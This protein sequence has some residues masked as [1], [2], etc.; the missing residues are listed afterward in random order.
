MS[1]LKDLSNEKVAVVTGSASGIGYHTL[2]LLAKNGFRTYATMRNITKASSIK[3]EANKQKLPL[4]VIQLD[5][6]DD[7][8][9]QGAIEKII[10]E[11]GRIDVLVNNAG[12]GFTRALEDLSVEEVKAQFETNFFGVIRVTQDVLPVMRK[13]KGPLLSSLRNQVR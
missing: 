3:D 12:Y 5:V 7:T 9:V 2:L 4:R 10:V 11:S 6:K 8:S 1:I 13:Q